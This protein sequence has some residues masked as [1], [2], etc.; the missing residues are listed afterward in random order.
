MPGD[1]K[2][3]PLGKWLAA[4]VPTE[5]LYE[6]FIYTYDLE[7]ALP[8]ACDYIFPQSWWLEA[9]RSV[10]W[11]KGLILSTKEPFYNWE[12][13]ARD[14]SRID[15]SYF[16]GIDGLRNRKRIWQLISNMREADMFGLQTQNYKDLSPYMLW[17]D[18]NKDWCWKSWTELLTWNDYS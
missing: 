18:D 12:R 6:I 11:M 5:I 3:M 10:V 7:E 9:I 14:I 2:E 1:R 13:L 17:L 16:P 4:R 15:E 8:S